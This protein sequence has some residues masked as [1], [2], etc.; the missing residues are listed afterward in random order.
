MALQESRRAFSSRDGVLSLADHQMERWN[1]SGCHRDELRPPVTPV[2][3][4]S[5]VGQVVL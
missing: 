3:S 4:S 1:M 5:Q 2:G